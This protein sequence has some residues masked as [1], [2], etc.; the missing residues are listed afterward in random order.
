LYP[1]YDANGNVGQLIDADAN[2]VAAYSYDPFGN[3]TEMAGAEAAGNPWRFS[4][5]PVEAWTEWLYFGYRW[6][7]AETGRWVSRD[8]IEESGGFNL[9]QIVG[10]NPTNW[11]DFLGLQQ[12]T[13]SGNETL[14]IEFGN[15]SYNSNSGIVNLPGLVSVG[16]TGKPKFDYSGNIEID[17]QAIA[18]VFCLVS[19]NATIDIMSVAGRDSNGRCKKICEAMA[20]I[21]NK[22]LL[23]KYVEKKL[24][25]AIQNSG[26]ANVRL[27]GE[28]ED[29]SCETKDLIKGW[30]GSWSGTVSVPQTG[31]IREMGRKLTNNQDK[32][33]PKHCSCDVT[34]GEFSIRG[35]EVR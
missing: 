30:D 18:K 1:T 24:Q 26:I 5:K 11:I 19:N 14:E 4:T 29:E 16:M 27:C 3:V 34:V 10:N 33:Y 9:Y 32:P 17:T 7:D 21:D 15:G 12:Q 31:V 35:I 2:V 25:E 20:N 8:P 23:K 6:Y 22:K 28:D 13:V